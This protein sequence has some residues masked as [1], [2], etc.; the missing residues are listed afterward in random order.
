M[1]CPLAINEIR[2]HVGW[3]N[4][5]HTAR[6]QLQGTPKNMYIPKKSTQEADFLSEYGATF[7]RKSLFSG[8]CTQYRPIYRSEG[9]KMAF[10]LM[11]VTVPLCHISQHPASE[12]G[13]ISTLPF[14]TGDAGN[15]WAHATSSSR[16]RSALDFRRTIGYESSVQIFLRP[17]IFSHN[18]FSHRIFRHRN[19]TRVTGS[20]L[21]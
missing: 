21:A 7:A 8:Y 17:I 1:E 5:M 9:H 4:M 16:Q 13:R 12:E 11:G 15:T 3:A 10:Q 19:A 14:S 20:D 2:S 18:R 6:Q